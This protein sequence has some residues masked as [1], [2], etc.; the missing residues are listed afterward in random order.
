MVTYSKR[1][2]VVNLIRSARSSY[3]VIWI[4]AILIRYTITHQWFIEDLI[5]CDTITDTSSSTLPERCFYSIIYIA[6][7]S[8]SVRVCL[9]S[10]L[11]H[12]LSVVDSKRYL[13]C[14]NQVIIDTM[15]DLLWILYTIIKLDNTRVFLIG[16]QMNHFN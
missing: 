5:M 7:I 1:V 15:L 16:C 8:L 6:D 9:Y 3:K 11:R 2:M 12:N 14:L 4:A 10:T 13:I